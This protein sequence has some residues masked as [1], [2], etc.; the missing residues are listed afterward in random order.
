MISKTLLQKK[1]LSLKNKPEQLF[2][3]A[4]FTEDQYYKVSTNTYFNRFAAGQWAQATNLK[5]IK[6]NFV[7]HFDGFVEIYGLSSEGQYIIYKCQVSAGLEVNVEFEPK[8]VKSVWLDFYSR[9]PIF[10]DDVNF[11]FHSKDHAYETKSSTVVIC[12]FNKASFVQQNLSLLAENLDSELINRVIIVNQGAEEIILPNFPIMKVIIQPNLGGSGGFARGISEFL[13]MDSDGIVLM[14][15]DI[16]FIPE[17]LYRLLRFASLGENKFA[18]STQM[19]NL[20]RPR[21]VWADQES[22][23]LVNLWGKPHGRQQFDAN[24]QPEFILGGDMVAWW[25][26]YFPR[27]YVQAAGLPLPFFIHWDDVEYCLRMQGI[28]GFSVKT[29]FGFGVW[30]EPFD[31]KPKWGWISYFDIRNALIAG[32]IYESKFVDVYRKV[33]KT[34]I[35][36]VVSHRYQANCAIQAG[37]KDFMTGSS[38]L[39]GNQRG[40]AT[41]AFNL[42]GI[43]ESI[44]T[45]VVQEKSLPIQKSRSVFSVV[46]R[47][48]FLSLRFVKPKYNYSILSSRLASAKLI[49]NSSHVEI[50]SPY[51][52]QIEFVAFNPVLARKTFSNSMLLILLFPLRWKV[53]KKKWINEFEYLKSEKFW[54]LQRSPNQ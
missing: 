51:G 22:V 27:S 7:A 25:C 6:L 19:L 36:T 17:I 21:E 10:E 8:G 42:P 2:F 24:E 40:R 9:S 46:I 11:E 31:G 33:I 43:P 13:K 16:V 28:N 1:C 47:S 14:D 37:I 5:K 30:H 48:L 39:L 54:E 32:S 52:G 53:S 4:S 35:V 49:Q 20:Y 44:K 18:I 41:E 3:L 45:P 38:C 12:T 29:I 15:D 23:D 50:L 26:G 34:L